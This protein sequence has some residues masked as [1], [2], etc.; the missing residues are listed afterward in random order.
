MLPNLFQIIQSAL[1]DAASAG[2]RGQQV[3][4][5]LLARIAERTGGQSVRANI[6]LLR[7]NAAVGA[8]IAAALRRYATG[9]ELP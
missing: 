2:V 9:E 6:A 3:T 1:D 4:P 5:Y 7:R 8:E